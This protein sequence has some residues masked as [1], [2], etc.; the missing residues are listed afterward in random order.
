MFYYTPEG[1]QFIIIIPQH[2]GA[3][4]GGFTNTALQHDLTSTPG[5][6]IVTPQTK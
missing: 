1:Y 3:N 4:G 2:C 5:F 6:T